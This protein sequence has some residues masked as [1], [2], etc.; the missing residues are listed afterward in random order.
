MNNL[1]N[2]EE[3]AFNLITKPE[4]HKATDRELKLAIALLK[5]ELEWHEQENLLHY[6]LQFVP[7]ESG[8]MTLPDGNYLEHVGS[9]AKHY[10]EA[11]AELHRI[12]RD[13]FVPIKAK[14]AEPANITHSESK[15]QLALEVFN[16]FMLFY[17]DQIV[18]N[19]NEIN[20]G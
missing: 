9:A 19:K 10:I 14:L 16:I 13:L 2:V 8:K 20:E 4:E 18:N 7:C 3:M 15:T 17:Q 11:A 1:R 5:K 12:N 6:I